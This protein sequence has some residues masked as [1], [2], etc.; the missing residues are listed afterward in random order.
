MLADALASFAARV[1]ALE[2]LFAGGGAIPPPPPTLEAGPGA[3]VVAPPAGAAVAATEQ[4][5]WLRL[6]ERYQKLRA[7]EFLGGADH[8]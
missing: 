8:W 2:A 6:V 4:E 1:G 3:A 5:I 7:P